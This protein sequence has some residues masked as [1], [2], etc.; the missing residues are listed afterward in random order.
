[1]GQIAYAKFDIEGHECMMM[2]GGLDLLAPEHRPNYIQTEVS[3]GRKMAGCSKAEY[4][5][6]FSD[7]N[8]TIRGGLGNEKRD[9]LMVGSNYSF[10]WFHIFHLQFK[11]FFTL[12]ST[13]DFHSI[14]EKNKKQKIF[15]TRLG[16]DNEKWVEEEEED[17]ED[18]D[19]DYDEK[20]DE[21]NHGLGR[22]NK[23]T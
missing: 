12:H 4:L 17:H 2:K 6:I 11:A 20:E 19:D 18:D 21:E 7:A 22:L 8:Y 9:Y 23:D 1:M 15:A 5:K 3:P 16:I 13:F 14:F 10:I